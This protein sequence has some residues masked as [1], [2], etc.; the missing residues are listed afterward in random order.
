MMTRITER[1]VAW[2]ITVFGL[3]KSDRYKNIGNSSS[4]LFQLSK[5]RSS[6][7]SIISLDGLDSNACQTARIDA[8]PT[9]VGFV[10]VVN[11]SICV[12]T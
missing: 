10:S 7:L 3:T 12:V 1:I 8:N 6:N 2:V 5:T 4:G 11:P 9:I